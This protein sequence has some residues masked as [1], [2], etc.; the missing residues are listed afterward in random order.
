MDHLPT[1]Q[2]AVHC[3]P[4]VPYLCTREPYDGPTPSVFRAR[5]GWEIRTNGVQSWLIRADAVEKTPEEITSFLQSWLYFGLLTEIFKLVGVAFDADHFV[6]VSDSRTTLVTTA[7]LPVLIDQWAGDQ[8]GKHIS[9]QVQYFQAVT[10][11]LQQSTQ[12]ANLMLSNGLITYGKV[13]F[14]DYPPSRTVVQSILCLVDTFENARKKIWPFWQNFPDPA[15]SSSR[16]PSLGRLTLPR[17][18]F[19]KNNWCHSAVKLLQGHA[20][21]DNNALMVACQIPRRERSKGHQSCSEVQCNANQVDDETYTCEHCTTD[22]EC[23]FLEVDSANVANIVL[24]GGTPRILFNECPGSERG[25]LEVVQDK[26]YIA[27]SHVW[28]HGLGNPRKNAL[29]FCQVKRLC[30]LALRVLLLRATAASPLSNSI[31][32]SDHSVAFWIDTLCI[33][34][35][36][37]FRTARKQAISQLAMTYTQ[38]S[39][40]L[41]VD[42]ELCSASIDC[43]PLE[44]QIRVLSCDWMRR[45]WTL[46]EAVVSRIDRLWWQFKERALNFPQLSFGDRHAYY[47]QQ[48]HFAIS[49]HLPIRI[50]DLNISDRSNLFYKIIWSLRFRQ[51]SRAQDEF[52]CIASMLNMNTRSLLDVERPVERMKLFLALLEHIPA[53][54]AFFRGEHLDEEGC[55]WMPKSFGTGSKKHVGLSAMEPQLCRFDARG[56]YLRLPAIKLHIPAGSTLHWTFTFFNPHD[57]FWYENIGNTD[58]EV[59][60]LPWGQRWRNVCLETHKRNDLALLFNGTEPLLEVGTVMLVDVIE[61]REDTIYVRY[62]SRADVWR[63]ATEASHRSNLHGEQ[64]DLQAEMELRD[65]FK[66]ELQKERVRYSAEEQFPENS[67]YI[68]NADMVERMG[69]EQRW[70]VG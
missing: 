68:L 47:A 63:R 14:E 39:A 28:S 40:V 29:R 52:I 41:V 10:A 50:Q 48:V 23:D 25:Q 70:C 22:C 31:L 4:V 35:G 8:L 67:M 7:L 62:L 6:V 53:Y 27:I 37:S 38:A 18:Y 1:V 17:E 65:G 54:V 5:K 42:Q 24:Q 55:R 11:V 66:R 9:V 21:V 30:R 32:K 33:P 49:A 3:L 61:T 2:D 51:T 43:S 12:L 59:D 56:I 15:A 26:E 44:K 69:P 16:T 36:A 19:A 13:L 57:R 45:L 34:V 60:E 58:G 64:L 46:Q 20:W